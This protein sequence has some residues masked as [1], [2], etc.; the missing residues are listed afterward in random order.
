[1]K[2]GCSEDRLKVQRPQLIINALDCKCAQEGDKFT[3]FY[4]GGGGFL[5]AISCNC[6]VG[7]TARLEVFFI[8]SQEPQLFSTLKTPSGNTHHNLPFLG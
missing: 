8:S 6:E 1:M 3:L 4:D 5:L 7:S 2:Y